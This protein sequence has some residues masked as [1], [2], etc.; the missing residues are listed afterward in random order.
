MIYAVCLV[1]VSYVAL[2]VVIREIIWVK[3]GV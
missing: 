3:L 2:T 1:A